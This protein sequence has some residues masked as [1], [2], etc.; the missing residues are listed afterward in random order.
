MP[1]APNTPPPDLHVDEGVCTVMFAFDI[2]RAIDLDLA[3]RLIASIADAD[4]HRETVRNSRRAPEHFDYRPL[5]LCITRPA[6]ALVVGG[7][8]AGP[9]LELTLYDFGAVSVA[10]MFPLAGP[11]ARLRDLSAALYENKSLLTEARSQ[12][13][14]LMQDLHAALDRPD[15][16]PIA[17]DYHVFHIARASLPDGVPTYDAFVDANRALVAGILRSERE[18]FSAQEIS[19]ALAARLSYGEQDLTLIDWNASIVFDRAAADTL[20]VLEFANV[21]LLELRALDDK[22]DRSLDE[23]YRIVQH[24]PTIAS[25]FTGGAG[26]LRRVA[27]LQMDS[28]ALFEGVNNALKLVGDQYLAR[29]YRL[30]AQRLHLPDWD[31]TV[32]RKLGTLDSVYQKLADRQ[33]NTRME[34]LEWIIILLI[35]FEV[36]RAILHEGL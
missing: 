5:P 25:R 18:P 7:F 32:L 30:A 34:I 27:R 13:D 19:E 31:S 6:A 16:V 1:D 14:R 23:A 11:F 12:L 15:V 17:E 2:A 22:L 3:E 10:F 9:T 29:L 21:E 36:V 8:H 35:A 24:P 26:R 28:A 33:A 20:S 4:G